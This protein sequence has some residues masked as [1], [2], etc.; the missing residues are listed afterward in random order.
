[1]GLS[2]TV[3][4]INSDFSRNRKFFLPRLFCAPAEGDSRGI[5]YQRWESKN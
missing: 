5:G 4:E 1:M 3:S 2:R